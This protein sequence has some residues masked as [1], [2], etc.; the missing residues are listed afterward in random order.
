LDLISGVGCGSLLHRSLQLQ[1]FN[2]IFIGIVAGIGMLYF[3]DLMPGRAGAATTLFTNSISSGVILAGVLQG[4][5]TETWGHNAV[6]VA[7]MVLVIL[8]LIICAKVREA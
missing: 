8:A 4:V 6:Y 7:A 2:A 5:L 3:Q 1:I